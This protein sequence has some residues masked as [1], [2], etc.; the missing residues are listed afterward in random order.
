MKKISFILKS[1]FIRILFNT[2][3]LFMSGFLIR[4]WVNSHLYNDLLGFL[5]LFISTNLFN[6]IFP[7]NSFSS[8]SYLN[9]RPRDKILNSNLNLNHRFKRKIEWILFWQYHTKFES[10]KEYKEQWDKNMKLRNEIYDKYSHIKSRIT[11]VKGTLSWFINR[12]N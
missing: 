4:S 10:Y 1:Y 3:L 11:V 8:I 2:L 6:G 12:R 9:N 5:L 7:M